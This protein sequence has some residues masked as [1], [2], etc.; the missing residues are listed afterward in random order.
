MGHYADNCPEGAGNA[1]VQE[2]ERNDT[3]QSGSSGSTES[4]QQTQ[5]NNQQSHGTSHVTITSW[6]CFTSRVMMRGVAATTFKQ[7]LRTWLLLDNQSTDNIFCNKDYLI[8]IRSRLWRA[9]VSAA[10]S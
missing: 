2:S 8:N 9:L 3:E 4:Q 5:S 1:N 6:N 10:Q 7:R